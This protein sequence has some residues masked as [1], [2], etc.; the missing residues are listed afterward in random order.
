MFEID[1]R[2]YRVDRW[3]LPVPGGVPLEGVAYF[4]AFLAAVILIGQLPVVG[5]LTSVAHPLLA[6]LFIPAGLAMV[7]VRAEP[8]GRS[9]YRFVGDWA[10]HKARRRRTIN[11]RPAPTSVKWHGRVRVLWDLDSPVQRR[12][13]IHGP[14]SVRFRDGATLGFTMRGRW[15]AR[16]GGPAK[17]YDAPAGETVEIRP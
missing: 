7:A 5:G 15:V 16:P 10:R 12:G 11:G 2:I 8:D 3:A 17:T 14:A 4:F 9:T 1:R 6:Y 13:R